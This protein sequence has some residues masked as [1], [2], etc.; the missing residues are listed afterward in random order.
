MPNKT[1]GKK[2]LTVIP[3]KREIT[4]REKMEGESA[5]YARTL[6]KKVADWTRDL[7][8]EKAKNEAILSSIGEGVVVVDQDGK[9][10]FVNK[11]FERL[12]GWETKE[13]LGRSIIEVIPR[14]DDQGNT[15]PFKEEIMPKVLSG[16]V[17]VANNSNPFYYVRKD[18]KK[19]PVSSVVS[20]IILKKRVIGAVE[21]SRDIT[22]EKE[23]D[24]MKT[25]FISL[26][27]HQLKTPVTELMG[28]IENILEGVTGDIT[29][30]QRQY[31]QEMLEVCSRA[32]RLISDLLSI[33]MIE[34]GALSMNMQQIRLKEIVDLSAKNY[35]EAIEKKDL[36]LSINEKDKDIV[37]FA[38]KDK[39]IEVLN[40]IIDNAVKFTDSGSI[41]IE[42]RGETGY[43][44]VEIKDTGT[45]MS[46][47][48]LNSLFKKETILKGTPVAGKGAGIGL[49][50]AKS[51]IQQQKGDISAT[52][53]LGG[54]STFT[55]K[56][57]RA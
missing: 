45:G 17:V 51:L 50:I 32:N 9:I 42:I 38:D 14:E 24:R 2:L 43:G 22:K 52:S 12:V 10:I 44:V 55:L 54:G 21:I 4:E 16:E 27:S 5:E 19:I 48:G 37:V 41:V 36:I 40:N 49:Y 15:I 6:E 13:M 28:F 29:D 56:I 53:V 46:D 18:K 35:L 23:I 30:K 39:T 31:F 3:A 20:P 1:P 8:I 25:E 7:V 33:S 11:V 47:E 57:P 34:R 26:A